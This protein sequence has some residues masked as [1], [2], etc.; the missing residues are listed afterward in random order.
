[1]PNIIITGATSG[2]GLA[3]TRYFASSSSSSS[4]PTTTPTKIALLDINP[5]LGPSLAASL[6]A[7]HPNTEFIFK[8]CDVASWEDQ[9][10]IFQSLYQ[11]EFAGVIDIVVAN[12]GVSEGGYTSLVEQD[13][14]TTTTTT[15][16]G[17]PKRPDVRVLEVNLVGV[18][19][20][21]KLG[22]YYM[23]HQTPA[24][25][26]E[27]DAAAAASRTG[28]GLIICTASNAGLY[29]LP[30][31]P[32]YAASKFGV[33]GLVRS[34]AGLVEEKGIRICA[35]A[36]AVLET[37]I[38]PKEL[39][40]GMVITPMATLIK[41]VDGFVKGGREVNGQV[42]EVHGDNTTVREAHAFVDA[43]TERNLGR[44][45]GLGWA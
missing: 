15:T 31:A 38:A 41:A 12:A 13:D 29:A 24:S 33:V 45:K 8:R 36:P 34:T 43:D 1:M 2:I 40:A 19:Y 10:A 35:L 26:S 5:S 9:S 37:N 7:E 32:L 18:V 44:F 21:V 4:S 25:P 11:N 39:Y 28:R 23:D 27:G 30:T 17:P 22:I 6:S 3:I 14:N 20:S 16:G 42:V